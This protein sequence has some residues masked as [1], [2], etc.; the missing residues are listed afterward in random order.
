MLFRP[1]TLIVVFSFVV[2]MFSIS[3]LLGNTSQL[4]VICVCYKLSAVNM[5]RESK[6]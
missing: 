6:I 5:V 1:A 2:A 4:S 3:L